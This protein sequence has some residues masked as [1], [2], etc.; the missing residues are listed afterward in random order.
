MA[1]DAEIS[2]SEDT[3][4]LETTVAEAGGPMV[5]EE[6]QNA[7]LPAMVEDLRAKDGVVDR[8]LAETTS[9]GVGEDTPKLDV[10]IGATLVP[11]DPVADESI[12]LEPCREGDVKATMED[13][14]VRDVIEA[15]RLKE[16]ME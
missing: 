16:E 13:V 2:I 9:V 10:S 6:P 3:G 12:G 14:N 5:I 1:D 4:K 15:E 11:A 8:S 7:E